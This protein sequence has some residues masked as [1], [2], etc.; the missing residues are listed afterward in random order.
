M[1]NSD[2]GAVNVG[3]NSGGGQVEALGQPGGGLQAPKD[4]DSHLISLR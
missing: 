2:C 3:V 1:R 4:L